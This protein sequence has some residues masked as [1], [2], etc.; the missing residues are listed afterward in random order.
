LVCGVKH[1]WIYLAALLMAATLPARAATNA[2]VCVVSIREE[3]THNTLFLVRRALNEAAA[4]QAAALVL[5]IDTNGGRVDATEDIMRL[6]Q[7]APMPA[8]AFVNQKAFSAGS[9]IA[10]ATD[11]IFM[12]SG[13]VIGAAMP[14]MAVPGEGAKELPK[15]YQEKMSSA[16]R[17]LVRTAAQQNGHNPDVFEAMVDP[18][19]ELKLDDKVISEK[20]KLLT[21]TDQEAAREYGTPPKPL[22]SAGTLDSIDELLS[23]VGLAGATIFRVEPAGFEVLG[24]WL[25]AIGPLL[26]MV[27]FVAIYLEMKTP[28]IGVP[29][30]VAAVCFALYFVGQFA[31]GLAGWED[32]AIFAL[33]VA[34]LAVEIL[35]LPGFGVT[36]ILGIG[37]ILTSLVLAMTHRFPGGPVLPAWPAVQIPMLKVLMSFAGSVVAMMLLARWLPQTSLFRRLELSATSASPSIGQD[38]LPVGATGVAETM[39]RPAGKGRF[40]GRLVDVMTEGDLIEAGAAIRIVEVRGSRVAVE[41][42]GQENKA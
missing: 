34:L 7:H 14:V 15:G 1:L 17:A 36:G 16:V 23:Q 26:M 2:T 38:A 19:V 8:Y 29:A 32:V 41:R 27:G 20:G 5:D 6:L 30:L 42:I 33:G 4:R 11:K 25:T 37:F 18:D 10:A 24:R 31:A 22:L 28:G 3:I 12:A 40:D 9:F 13:S 35:V 21:L 39:L